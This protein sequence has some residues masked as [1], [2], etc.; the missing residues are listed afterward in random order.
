MARHRQDSLVHARENGG[1]V[2][3]Q[4][5]GREGDGRGKPGDDGHPAGQKPQGRVVDVGEKGVFAPGPGH[6]GA[7]L[8]VAQGPAKGP[9]PPQY[10]QQQ[11][12]K[13]GVQALHLEAQGGEDPGADHV[14][15]HDDGGGKQGDWFY[16]RTTAGYLG[17]AAVALVR[18]AP[19]YPAAHKP[20]RIR[21]R[22]ACQLNDAVSARSACRDTGGRVLTHVQVELYN[23]KA[24]QNPPWHQGHPPGPPPVSQTRPAAAKTLLLGSSG[25]LGSILR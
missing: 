18:H 16:C 25:F 17:N 9:H 21:N 1:A 4:G 20:P 24:R 6:H 14:G 22:I 11:H 7:E 23:R 8:A 10:P 15:H 2:L 12:G 19:G 13:G 3:T 5:D